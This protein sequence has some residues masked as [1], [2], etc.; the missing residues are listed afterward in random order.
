MYL[1]YLFLCGDGCFDGFDKNSS[2]LGPYWP[3]GSCGTIKLSPTK[4]YCN[5]L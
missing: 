1:V 3:K 2:N 4:L 5:N